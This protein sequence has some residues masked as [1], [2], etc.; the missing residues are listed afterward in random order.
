MQIRCRVFLTTQ[1]QADNKPWVVGFGSLCEYVNV[2]E[3]RDG[4]KE[5]E[6]TLLSRTELLRI[7]DAGG[8][9]SS[10]FHSFDPPS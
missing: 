5:A 3:G 7:A 2:V 10:T 4:R 1:T 6:I 8:P 9:S